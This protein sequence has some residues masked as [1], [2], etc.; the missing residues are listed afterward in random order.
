M[1]REQ[2]KEQFPDATEEQITAI[3]DINGTDITHAKKNNIDPKELRRLQE[4]ETEYTNYR[5]RASRMLKKQQKRW[6]M[7]R[8]LRL[9][10]P[11]NQTV[12]M[13][14]KFL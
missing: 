10:L 1:T 5:K 8:R 14:R 2:V 9:I 6:Q 7:Q 11:K 13:Q 3:L 12:L 4:I